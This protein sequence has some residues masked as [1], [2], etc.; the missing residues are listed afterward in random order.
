MYVHACGTLPHAPWGLLEVTERWPRK[1]GRR[2]TCQGLV[3]V[4]HLIDVTV[5][6]CHRRVLAK[7]GS[8]GRCDTELSVLLLDRLK[9][10][11][12]IYQ[13]LTYT[14]HWAM[15][16]TGIKYLVPTVTL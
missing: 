11:I 8:L 6:C 1:I 14:G 10:I 16:F 12:T 5:E 3:Y 2:A 15:G 13:T 9:I 7:V 4:G